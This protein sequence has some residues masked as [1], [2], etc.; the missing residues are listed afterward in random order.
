M[1]GN[2]VSYLDPPVFGVACPRAMHFMARD[3]L[4][5]KK[6]FAWILRQVNAFPL[7][8]NAADIWALKEALRVLKAGRGLLLFP[9]GTRTVGGDLGKPQAGVGFLVR[10]SGVPVIPAYVEGSDR[11]LPK[12]EK[13]FHFFR[14]I[15]VQ[16]GK[17]FYPD[18]KTLTD[19]EVSLHVMEKIRELR[20][21]ESRGL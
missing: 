13:K 8:R 4:F 10:K 3:T 14:P 12:Q 5:K 15:H 16:I 6:N 17:P 20:P 21:D 1:C 19:E 2:H 9:E 7:K 18:C 11:A